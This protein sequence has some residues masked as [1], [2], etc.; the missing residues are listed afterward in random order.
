VFSRCALLPGAAAHEG[1]KDP[2]APERAAGSAKAR[3]RGRVTVDGQVTGAWS[4]SP[5]YA[6][7]L[8]V[9][10]LHHRSGLTAGSAPQV[11]VVAKKRRGLRRASG[12]RDAPLPTARTVPS[13]RGLRP[14]LSSRKFEEVPTGTG[15]NQRLKGYRVPGQTARGGG[16]DLPRRRR[17]LPRSGYDPRRRQERRVPIDLLLESVLLIVRSGQGPAPADRR[18]GHFGYLSRRCRSGQG[19]QVQSVISGQRIGK[20]TAVSATGTQITGASSTTWRSSPASSF[21]YED[22]SWRVISA[23]STE[24]LRH[25]HVGRRSTMCA[26]GYTTRRP[27]GVVRAV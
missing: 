19:R 26:L 17:S 4:S 22:K 14:S 9:R 20:T 5:D 27:R 3:P 24:A 2:D 7:V 16:A 15:P 18:G 12:H 6:D 10:R 1:E 13:T 23:R 8:A 11:L 25:Q 21:A